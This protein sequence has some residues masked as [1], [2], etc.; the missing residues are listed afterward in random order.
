VFPVGRK[1]LKRK[2]KKSFS[3]LGKALT[4]GFIETALNDFA[5]LKG[6]WWNRK[7]NFQKRDMRS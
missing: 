6:D 7:K 3:R 5:R 4:T 2:L 1:K